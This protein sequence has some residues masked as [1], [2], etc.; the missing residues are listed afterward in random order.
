MSSPPA[1]SCTANAPSRALEQVRWMLA[2]LQTSHGK[3]PLVSRDLAEPF[4]TSHLF[5]YEVVTCWPRV[6]HL[7]IEPSCWWRRPGLA[8]AAQDSQEGRLLQRWGPSSQRS[9]ESL[10]PPR[11]SPQRSSRTDR[12][13]LLYHSKFLTQGF[14]QHRRIEPGATY[15]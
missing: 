6:C 15:L 11:G 7:Q 14:C 8:R 5:L 9:P 12:S 4:S 3:A 13:L 1:L 10:H 2:A